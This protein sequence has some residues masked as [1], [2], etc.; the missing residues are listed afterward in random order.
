MGGSAGPQNPSLAFQLGLQR[1]P[2]DPS[3]ARA[4]APRLSPQ[5]TVNVASRMESQGVPNATQVTEPVRELLK[6]YFVFESRGP[7]HLKNWAGL[8]GNP[9]N[10]GGWQWVSTSPR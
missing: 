4:N 7:L 9:L 1:T 3:F 10:P 2:L 6:D 5:D 8:D